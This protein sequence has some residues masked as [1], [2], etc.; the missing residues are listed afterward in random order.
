MARTTK[1]TKAA[2]A[3]TAGTAAAVKTAETAAAAVKTAETAAAASA[4]AKKTAEKKTV[5]KKAC[6]TAVYV[7]LEG[8]SV[9]VADI[10]TAVKNA[11]KEKGLEASELKI[12]INAA[13]QAAYY[14]VN[15][16]GGE[17]YKVDLKSL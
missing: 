17:A 15:G 1:T 16:E 7:E 2:A 12:Y 4:P 5:A 8:L 9:D 3:K 14:T 13:E 10:Q 11:V 6:K